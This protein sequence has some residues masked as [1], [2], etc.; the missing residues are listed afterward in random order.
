MLNTSKIP[1]PV[2]KDHIIV[3][4]LYIILYH[5]DTFY[6]YDRCIVYHVSGPS[7]VTVQLG[8]RIGP[9]KR[10]GPEILKPGQGLGLL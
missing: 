8:A 2:V 1:Y 9:P 5:L 10:R 7:M 3:S 6:V 4:F